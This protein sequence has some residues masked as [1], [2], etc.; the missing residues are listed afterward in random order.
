MS[1][2]TTRGRRGRRAPEEG[3]RASLKQLLPFLFEHRRVLM[4]VVILSIVG[5]IATQEYP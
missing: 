5:A 4:I 3:P 2:T 1:S